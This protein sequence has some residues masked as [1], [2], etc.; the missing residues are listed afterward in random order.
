MS[1]P[2]NFEFID[3][4]YPIL[5]FT[6]SKNVAIKSDLTHPVNGATPKAGSHQQ[7]GLD[8]ADKWA[9]SL[10][11]FNNRTILMQ[12]Q[13]YNSSREKGSTPFSKRKAEHQLGI[14]QLTGNIVL[15]DVS[16]RVKD[17]LAKMVVDQA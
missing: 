14:E 3:L 10:S 12:D 15:I 17:E 16:K 2:T 5:A 7:T 1:K 4:S 6:A 9:T 13:N 8:P 11:Y